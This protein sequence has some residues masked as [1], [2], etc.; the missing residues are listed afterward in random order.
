MPPSFSFGF[1]RPAILMISY[2]SCLIASLIVR[3]PFNTKKEEEEDYNLLLSL[4]RGR[5][6]RKRTHSDCFTYVLII[7]RINFVGSQVAQVCF[8]IPS[9]RASSRKL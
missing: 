1:E 3:A 5:F 6:L 8:V 4:S 2:T 7:W 9:P